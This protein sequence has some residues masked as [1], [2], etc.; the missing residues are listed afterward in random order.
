MKLPSPVISTAWLADHLG[1]PGLRIYD[2]SLYV[3]Y[4]GDSGTSFGGYNLDSETPRKEWSEAHIPG[5]NFID[6]NRDLFDSDNPVPFMMPDPE[7]FA[8]AIS[9]NGVADGTGVVL[10]S[11]GS[12]MWATRI[13][14]M[15]RSIGFE[16]AAILDGGWEKWQREGRPTDDAPTLY[17]A[18]K[19]S[20][21]AH[22]EM[23]VD[24]EKMLDI[25]ENGGPVMLNALPPEVYTGELNRYGRPGHVPGSY[26]VASETLLNPETGEFLKPDQLRPLFTQSGA[27]EADE[28]IAYCGGGIS[29]TMDCL[30]MCLCGQKKVAVYDGSMNEWVHDDSLPLKLGNEP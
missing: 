21:N 12:M 16:N 6:I 18:G 30:A 19:L 15:L 26:N 10:F 5:S 9:A 20:V 29:A 24:K 17:P 23:W 2:V 27:L 11:K 1:E 28:V 22:P 3:E 25:I 13:W 14:Y 7:V 4:K 8:D